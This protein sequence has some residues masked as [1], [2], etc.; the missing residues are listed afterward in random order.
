MPS[1]LPYLVMAMGACGASRGARI[2]NYVASLHALSDLHHNMLVMCIKGGKA[3]T[4]L[5]AHK[6][7]ASPAPARETH[8]PVRR[9]PDGSAGFHGD[10]DT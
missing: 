9:R 4:M 5:Q 3:K 6:M 10:V 2:R 7:S 1:I 8:N